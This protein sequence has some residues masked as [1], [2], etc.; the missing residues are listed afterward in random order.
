MSVLIV[1]AL[2][3]AKIIHVTRNAAATCWSNFKTYFSS[4]GLGYSYD[5]KDVVDYYRLYEDLMD[6]WQ[7]EYGQ[8]IYRLDYDLLTVNQETETKRLIAH[9]GLDWD[10]AC[11]FPLHENKKK[12]TYSNCITRTS[13]TAQLYKGSS[14][15]W[16]K[17]EPYLDGSHYYQ[18]AF[19]HCYRRL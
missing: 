17:F 4:N 19:D 16:R 14:E 8:L 5:L 11:L 7:R 6:Y 10:T 12:I 9:L 18:A 13:K 3:E 15:E 1:S 2:P